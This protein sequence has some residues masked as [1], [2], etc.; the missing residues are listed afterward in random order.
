[1]KKFFTLLVLLAVCEGC[2]SDKSTNN[3]SYASPESQGVPTEAIITFMDDLEKNRFNM[4]SF[5]LI[6]NGLTLAECYWPFFNAD[7]KH[8]MYSVSKS[9]TSVA[10]G[11]MIDEGRISLD[12]KV[13]DF[14]PEYLPADP[15]PFILQATVR[16][17]LMMATFNESTSYNQ[18]SPDWV[19]TFFQDPGKKHEPG[20]LFSY[21]TAATVV[22]CGIVEKLNGKLILEYMR[23]VFDE[24]GI[25]KDIWCIK[26]PDGRS[27]TGS[28]VMCTTR[29]FAR[30]ALLCLNKGAWNGKQLIS[31]EY[32]EAATSAQIDNSV[33]AGAELRFGYGYQ[34]WCLRDGGFACY[35][36]GGQLAMCLPSQNMIMITTADNQAIAN[37]IEPIIEAFFRLA[38]KTSKSSLPKNP[39]AQQRLATK[40]AT[41][42]TPLPVGG[43]TTANAAKFSGVRYTMGDNSMEIKW[44]SVDITPEKCILHYENSTG[45]HNLIL[46][47]GEY[48]FQKFPEKYYGANIGVKDTNYD[49][50]AAGAWKDDNT[51]SGTIYS[52]DDHLGTI[53]VTLS[54]LEGK[55]QVTMKKTAEWF[56]DTY[57]GTA[58]GI[59][60]SN[61]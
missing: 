28:G 33:R 16:H 40:M 11:M 23:P 26:S 21:D 12:D 58:E 19:A 8:R 51:L 27:W 53:Y 10:I 32:M 29:D 4:H 50:I 20:T 14:F 6:R 38:G 56:F 5:L 34:F 30:F 3:L 25:S 61:G 9:F 46:G 44:M 31:S 13:A 22:L 52:I 55:L 18:Y 48:L 47:M 41:V 1:M 7:K 49:A 17:L 37:G 35:G 54:F 2:G 39:E 43:K 42:S 45:E 60:Q 36:M 59:I 57:Q 24:I 15:H